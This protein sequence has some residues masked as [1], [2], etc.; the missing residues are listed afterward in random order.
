MRD[1]DMF[2]ERPLVALEDKD[3]GLLSVA[4]VGSLENVLGGELVF[5][6]CV[7]DALDVDLGPIQRLLTA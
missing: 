1:M 5:L 4:D 6:D 2:F 3:A 7:G